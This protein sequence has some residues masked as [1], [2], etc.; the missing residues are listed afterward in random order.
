MHPISE[1]FNRI[2]VF[3]AMALSA[4]GSKLAYH[5]SVTGSPQVWTAAVPKG[6]GLL[7]YPKPLTSGKEQQPHVL[8]SGGGE[9]LQWIGN[10]RLLCLMDSHG[11]EQTYIQIHDFKAGKVTTVPRGEK[12]SRDYMAFV[13]PSHR[14]LHFLSNRGHLQSQGMFTYDLKSGEI[15]EWYHHESQASAWIG[16]KI[17]KGSLLFI[18]VQSNQETTLHAIHPKTKKITDIY[19]QPRTLILPLAVV[20]NSKIL[21]SCNYSRQFSSLAFLNP[22]TGDLEFLEKDQWDVQNAELSKTKKQ[23]LVSRNVAGRSQLELYAFP[24][25]KKQKV[26]F[27]SEGVVDGLSIAE[28][29]KFA[30]FEYMSPVEPRNYYRLDLKTKKVQQLTDNWTSRIPKNEFVLPQLV[31]YESQGRKIHSWF[32]LPKGAKKSKSLPVVIWP[33]GGPQWQERA[34]FRP[35]FQYFVSRGFALWAP[36]PHG[37]TGYGKDFTEAIAG[38]WGTADLPDMENGIQWLKDSGWIDEKRI[39][40]MGGS[41]GGYMTLRSLTKIPKT[42]KAA[43]DIFGVCNLLTFVKTVPP[44]WQPFMDKLVG[45]PEKDRE[46]LIEQSPINSLNKIDCPLMVVQGALDPRVVK[47]ESDQVVETLKKHGREVEYLVFDDEGHGFLK[48]DNELKAYTSA[49]SF[50]EKHL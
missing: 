4:D 14:R 19:T 1:Y 49:A 46:K 50:L 27:K 7:Q 45:N 28:D 33:H 31:Q 41:Y 37:S 42:F 25:M 6:G 26:Y 18:R 39:A 34:N 40:I 22:E 35:I 2:N 48:Q 29:G 36:N 24:S 8:G 12:G 20:S 44:D 21:V 47:A 3:P 43:V 38:Q 13:D 5:S 23:L 15:E 10:D 17:W 11:D 32:F 16:N 9:A 30:V